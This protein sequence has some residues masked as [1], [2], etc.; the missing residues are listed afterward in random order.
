[1]GDTDVA[2]H[3]KFLDDLNMDDVQGE[4]R[5][6]KEEWDAVRHDEQGFCLVY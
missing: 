4:A 1:M 2:W 3:I 5:R 6:F